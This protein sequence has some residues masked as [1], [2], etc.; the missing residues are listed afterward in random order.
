MSYYL[1]G[2]CGFPGRIS[3]SMDV[4][5][6]QGLQDVFL[7]STSFVFTIEKFSMELGDEKWG[8]NVAFV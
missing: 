7:E 1:L 8:Y 6:I 4:L 5:Q 3:K 2:A